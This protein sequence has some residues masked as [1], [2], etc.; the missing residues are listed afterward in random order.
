MGDHTG[1]RSTPAGVRQ[2]R[3]SA[4]KPGGRDACPSH[5]KFG[6]AGNPRL[7]HTLPPPDGDDAA[8]EARNRRWRKSEK[9][10]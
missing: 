6:L 5:Q 4:A 10:G 9:T 7:S 1:Q 2:G 8:W 3:Q